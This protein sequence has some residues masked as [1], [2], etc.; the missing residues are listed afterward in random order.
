[1]SL[2]V[3][4]DADFIDCCVYEYNV[5]SLTSGVKVI[6]IVKDS[7]FSPCGLDVEFNN[8]IVKSETR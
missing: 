1:M 3:G 5:R 2:R 8:V 4:D 7:T 6:D